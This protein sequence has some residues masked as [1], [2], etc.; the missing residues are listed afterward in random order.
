MSKPSRLFNWRC[1]AL[2]EIRGARITNKRKAEPNVY[3]SFY[4]AFASSNIRV[5]TYRNQKTGVE[6]LVE[7]IFAS[8]TVFEMTSNIALLTTECH[9]A[10]KQLPI[11]LL[12]LL[13]M[14]QH[15]SH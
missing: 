10:K 8:P 7:T 15:S 5:Y 3:S 6:V 14:V 1:P 9:T 11:F 12:D 13:G 4:A 2:S